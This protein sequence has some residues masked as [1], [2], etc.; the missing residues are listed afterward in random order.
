[1][2]A[3]EVRAQA[4]DITIQSVTASV[5]AATEGDPT[6]MDN[7]MRKLDREQTAAEK[8][9]IREAQ[10]PVLK[11]A[12]ERH[13][14]RLCSL[15]GAS[16]DAIYRSL[17]WSVVDEELRPRGDDA[18]SRVHGGYMQILGALIAQISK[19]SGQSIAEEWGAI[20]REMGQSPGIALG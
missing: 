17:L 20:A 6:V 16:A 11:E 1:M 19:A 9:A 18:Q 4:R 3:A 14:D 5:I 2:D 13:V 10:V 15:S 8:L 7:L 12:V